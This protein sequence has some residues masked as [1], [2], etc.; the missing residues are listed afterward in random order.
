MIYKNIFFSSW[1]TMKRSCGLEI[2]AALPWADLAKFGGGQRG[3][4]FRGR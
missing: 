1:G 4:P 2:K 3:R